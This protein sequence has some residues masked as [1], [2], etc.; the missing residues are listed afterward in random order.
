MSTHRQVAFR[1]LAQSGD[2]T[3]RLRMGDNGLY[4]DGDVIDV[5]RTQP[6][7]NQAFRFL[8]DLGLI[9]RAREGRLPIPTAEGQSFL[10][11]VV[12]AK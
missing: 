8:H 3:R 9:A 12:D 6:R 7:L 10:Q 5:A 2:D 1:K 4:F 11:K